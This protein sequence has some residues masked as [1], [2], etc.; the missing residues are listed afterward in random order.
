[1]GR[2]GGRARP[3]GARAVERLTG[4]L[5]GGAGAEDQ[6]AVRGAAVLAADRAG[7]PAGGPR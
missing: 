5:A 3:S 6:L 2:A 4:V 1:M 7:P